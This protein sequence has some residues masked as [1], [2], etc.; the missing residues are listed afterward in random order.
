MNTETTLAERIKRVVG[1]NVSAFSRASDIGES[2]LRQYIAGSKPGLDK[3]AA[4]AMAGGVSLDWL[5]T[6]EGPMRPDQ[7]AAD[8]ATGYGAAERDMTAALQGDEAAEE[9]VEQRKQAVFGRL[10]EINQALTDMVTEVGYQPST[11]W[12]ETIKTLMFYHGL[13]DA[14]AARLIYVL[15][16]QD[17]ENAKRK[18]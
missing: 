2:L 17:V 18:G 5:A 13:D 9:R 4:I 16:S 3:A 6:G 15:Q 10:R 12:H 7:G 11:V 1:D 14:G 8:K